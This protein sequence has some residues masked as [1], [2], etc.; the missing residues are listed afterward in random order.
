MSSKEN[1]DMTKELLI[2]GSSKPM[3]YINFAVCLLSLLILPM[4]LGFQMNFDPFSILIL[5]LSSMFLSAVSANNYKASAIIII[6]PSLIFLLNLRENNHPTE[7]LWTLFY[8]NSEIQ[9]FK[10]VKALA[11]EV[12]QI[13]LAIDS[14]RSIN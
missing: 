8:T 4:A 1:T 12:N 9:N 5:I 3:F 11:D 13:K 7:G 10:Q 6:I 14:Y 2:N